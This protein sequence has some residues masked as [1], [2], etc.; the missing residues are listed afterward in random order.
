MNYGCGLSTF[1]S[2][3]PFSAIL[4]GWRIKSTIHMQ[5]DTG[6]GICDLQAVAVH[7]QHFR[8]EIQESGWETLCTNV[9]CEIAAHPQNGMLL[10]PNFEFSCA[11]AANYI[12][13]LSLLASIS[14]SCTDPQPTAGQPLFYQIELP[15]HPSLV[16]PIRSPCSTCS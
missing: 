7:V 15:P 9:A 4:A 10:A 11:E 14:R 6:T 1:Q 13:K 2:T 8:S 3:A 12:L 5:I 16:V